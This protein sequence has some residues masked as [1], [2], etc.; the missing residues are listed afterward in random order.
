MAALGLTMGAL[1][2]QAQTA[3]VATV[4]SGGLVMGDPIGCFWT[5]LYISSRD[6]FLIFNKG[7][8]STGK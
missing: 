7:V 1:S 8:N 4:P 3:P 5:P 2:G 6:N